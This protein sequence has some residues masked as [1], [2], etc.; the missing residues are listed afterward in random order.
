MGLVGPWGRRCIFRL[1]FPACFVLAPL[2]T[3]L[4][5]MP[6]EFGAQESDSRQAGFAFSNDAQILTLGLFQDEDRYYSQGLAGFWIGK[7]QPLKNCAM[8]IQWIGQKLNS[9]F[10]ASSLRFGQELFT[11]NDLRMT[12]PAIKD[13]RPFLGW[14]HLDFGQRYYMQFG[15]RPGRLHIQL[16]LGVVGP[17]SFG[18][19]LQVW[20]HE[21]RRQTSPRPELDPDPSA[22]WDM[23]YGS[24]GFPGRFQFS[25]NQGIGLVK[26]RFENRMGLD[27]GAETFLNA[28]ALFGYV[29]FVAQIRSGM[30][31]RSLYEPQWDGNHLGW[32]AFAFARSEINGVGWNSAITGAAGSEVRLARVT[33]Q[34]EFGI[35]LKGPK[36]LPELSVSWSM[37]SRETEENPKQPFQ[38]GHVDY[39]SYLQSRSPWFDHG[40]GTVR[41][42]WLW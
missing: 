28:G 14:A 6:S 3:T 38:S 8:P 25:V 18:K 36:P 24:D 13:E 34:N 21:M 40:F 17:G 5:A 10:T 15:D 29:G 30:L 22:G 2:F 16:N 26:Q 9:K 35:V 39:R 1:F 41:L 27:F 20:Y 19:E 4:W 12:A 11:P 42:V 23:Q 33:L 31:T 37:W 7:P 32:E